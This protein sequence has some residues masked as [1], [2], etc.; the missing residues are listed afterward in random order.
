M[1][2]I[3]DERRE[4]ISKRL[5]AFLEHP[6]TLIEEIDQLDSYISARPVRNTV[7]AHIDEL[8]RRL[9]LCREIKRSLIA[10]DEDGIM[11]AALW[12]TLLTGNID[13]LQ[14]CKNMPD[15]P[16]RAFVVTMSIST[17]SKLSAKEPL[18]LEI[19]LTKTPGPLDTSLDTMPTKRAPDA[20]EESTEAGHCRQRGN[21]ACVI[22]GRSNPEVCHIFPH[23][24]LNNPTTRRCTREAL[25]ILGSMYG[26]ESIRR[27]KEVLLVNEGNITDQPQNMISMCSLLHQW[28]GEGK[29]ALKP[30]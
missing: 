28:W 9:D 4:E 30:I 22:T 24:S 27:W 15:R 3:T 23:S 21:N 6:T 11:T 16:H 19:F 29:F 1:A 20:Q 12:A 5:A 7:P 17:L 26:R 13:C 18:L 10:E 8:E 2:K 25:G 14:E